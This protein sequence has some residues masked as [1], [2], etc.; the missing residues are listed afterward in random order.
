[1]SAQIDAYWGL[2]D[3]NGE[4]TTLRV[5]SFSNT[6][7]TFVLLWPPVKESFIARHRVRPRIEV[8]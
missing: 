1:M 8:C 2:N 7:R 6:Y 4:M 3:R 5:Q